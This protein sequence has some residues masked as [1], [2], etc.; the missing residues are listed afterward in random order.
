VTNPFQAHDTAVRLI[1]RRAALRQGRDNG[2]TQPSDSISAAQSRVGL[3]LT[4]LAQAAARSPAGRRARTPSVRPK[5]YLAGDDGPPL[6]LQHHCGHQ[7][8]AQVICR[9]CGEP[10]RAR[11]TRPVAVSGGD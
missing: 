10:L 4:R 6:V 2:V 5:N 8:T 3:G 1:Y 9:A 7:L 11:D